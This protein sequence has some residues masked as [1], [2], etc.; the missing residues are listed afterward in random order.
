MNRTFKISL[1]IIILI[2]LKVGCDKGSNPITG[3]K[4]SSDASSIYKVYLQDI[5]TVSDENILKMIEVADSAGWD[6]F[7]ILR[8]PGK[9]D[10]IWYF[11]DVEGESVI[12]FEGGI[13]Y[14]S[15]STEPP[16]EARENL[17]AYLATRLDEL[18]AMELNVDTSE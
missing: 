5:T 6:G 17:M 3:L 18:M 14:T 2:F 8:T 13:S 11:K 1:L 4:T 10:E 16:E 7:A 12:Q 15:Y 9:P